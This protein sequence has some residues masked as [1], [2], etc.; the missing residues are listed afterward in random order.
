MPPECV[1]KHFALTFVSNTW[2]PSHSEIST[3]YT[4]HDCDLAPLL[5]KFWSMVLLSM[6]PR[7]LFM[8]SQNKRRN[9]YLEYFPSCH[10]YASPLAVNTKEWEL[11]HYTVYGYHIGIYLLLV[12]MARNLWI[13]STWIFLQDSINWSEISEFMNAQQP[14]QRAMFNDLFLSWNDIRWQSPSSFHL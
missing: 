8:L 14:T 5:V 11:M 4:I 12:L 2:P 9:E 3:K 7:C 6:P 13:A 1:L 10:A